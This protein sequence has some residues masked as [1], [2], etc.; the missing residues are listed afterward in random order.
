MLPTQAHEVLCDVALFPSCYALN[1][2]W[3]ALLS[4]QHPRTPCP[5]SDAP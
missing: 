5:P 4:T 3:R 2:F 1:A